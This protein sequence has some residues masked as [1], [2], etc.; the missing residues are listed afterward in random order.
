MK[1]I[2]F[3]TFVYFS[4]AAAVAHRFSAYHA[5][6]DSEGLATIVA[7]SVKW[8]FW[9]SL[10]AT[11]LILA[12]G[13]P[14]LALFGPQFVDAYPVMFILAVGLLARAAVG[15]TERLLTMVGQQRVCVLAYA[16]ALVVN[17]TLCFALGALWRTWLRLT[18]AAFVTESIRCR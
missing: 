8:I 9:P 12:L 3:V 2:S 1:T 13:K 18:S 7:S 11:L 17:L 6:G 4:V 15:P 14:V 5:A 16:A 10:A